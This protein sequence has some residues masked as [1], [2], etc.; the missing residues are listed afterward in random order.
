MLTLVIFA[1]GNEAK[2]RGRNAVAAA[3][4]VSW[5]R[6]SRRARLGAA[7]LEGL[8]RGMGEKV[9]AGCAKRAV[10]IQLDCFVAPLL[11]MTILRGIL[12]EAVRRGTSRFRGVAL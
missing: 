12:S 4:M 5:R 1:L 9:I 3:A 11:A 2:A 10:A 8:N 7:V 6:K